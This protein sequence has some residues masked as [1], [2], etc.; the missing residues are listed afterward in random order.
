MPNATGLSP[1]ESLGQELITR[2]SPPSIAC[3]LGCLERGESYR[4]FMRLV[5]EFVPEVER[6]IQRLST[7]GAKLQLFAKTFDNR[8]FPL[9]PMFEDGMA[10]AY[11]VLTLNIP[12][13]L[14]S[15]NWEDYGEIS[16]GLYRPAI[17]LIAYLAED[18]WQQGEGERIALAE[19]CTEYVPAAILKRVPEEIPREEL[20]RLLHGTRFE[21]IFIAADIIHMDTGNC[22]FD[23]DRESI[24]QG[25]ADLDWT[26]D[27]VKELT[28]KWLEANVLEDKA[29]EIYDW[30][31]Q[32][33]AA[34]FAEII[35]FI[36]ARRKQLSC[37]PPKAKDGY[38]P[39]K[40]NIQWVTNLV[41]KMKVGTVWIAP[42]GFSF[43]KVGESHLCLIDFKD[44]PQVREV[45]ERT[46][47]IGRI[48]G[49]VMDTQMR[50]P[51]GGVHGPTSRRLPA[52]TMAS[53][54]IP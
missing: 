22:F 52:I 45:L 12:V 13:I 10:E 33:P 49:I 11:E 42:L 24:Y 6:E 46:L 32:K 19:A 54:P 48:A 21:G 3:L 35:D 34:R 23:E 25:S 1:L 14:R 40:A 17:M 38:E 37:P 15:I 29:V 18:P 47:I 5:H 16:E 2:A 30:L 43:I 51:E 44:T 26:A 7:P 36:E 4:E 28:Q 8:Y 53:P 41:K 31:E 27:N 9:H 50:F 20:H 39:T